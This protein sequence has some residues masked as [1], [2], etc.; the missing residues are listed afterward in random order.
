M[1]DFRLEV[2]PGAYSNEDAYKLV[3]DYIK[4]KYYI[5]GYGFSLSPTL[6]ILQQYQHAQEY[7]NQ[8]GSRLIWHFV[9]T[10]SEPWK[11]Q[12]LL[13]LANQI[14]ILFS[15]DYQVLYGLDTEGHAPHLHFGV[16]AFS[17]HPDSPI[18]SEERLRT[19]LS[20]IE[21]LLLSQFPGRT[22]TLQF[23][24]KKG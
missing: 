7:S 17:Y 13:Q 23:Q 8:T 18:L 16:N 21:D 15:E 20:M 5:C 2:F 22:F 9:L 3:L 10:F 4:R 6:S 24:G 11:Y 12:T 19:Y 1:S 14:A